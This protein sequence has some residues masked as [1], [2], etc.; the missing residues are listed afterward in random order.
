VSLDQYVRQLGACDKTVKMINLW[1]QVMHGL[2]STEESAAFF[3]DYC[4]RNGGLFSIRADDE[5]GGNHQRLHGGIFKP[6]S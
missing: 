1:V 4:R 6:S 3:I 2:D 5:S